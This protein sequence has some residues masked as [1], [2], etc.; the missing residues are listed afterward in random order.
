[1]VMPATTAR[2]PIDMVKEPEI[3]PALSTI[4]PDAP[5]EVPKSE[6]WPFALNDHVEVLV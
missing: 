2:F 4:E 6:V 5:T 3:A 1:M